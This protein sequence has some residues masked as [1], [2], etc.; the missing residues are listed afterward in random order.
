MFLFW[1]LGAVVSNDLPS[2]KQ[3]VRYLHAAA[4]FPVKDTWIKAIKAGNFNTLRTITPKT[5]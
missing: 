4:G 1:E 3:T 5:V 2:I